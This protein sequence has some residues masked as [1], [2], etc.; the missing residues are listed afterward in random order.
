M[1][2]STSKGVYRS[3]GKV[4][5]SVLKDEEHYFHFYV[6]TARLLCPLKLHQCH[7]EKKIRTI[8]CCQINCQSGKCFGTKSQSAKE[9]RGRDDDS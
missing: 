6:E 4:C 3:F 9:K 8:K 1:E 5:N 2:D 7:K